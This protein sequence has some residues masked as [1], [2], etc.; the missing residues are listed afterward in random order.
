[1][2][3][4]PHGAVIFQPV[5][6]GAVLLHS[7]TEIYYGLNPVGARIWELIA[8]GGS[9]FEDLVDAIHEAYPDAER[10]T[11]RVDIRELLTDLET[12]G[13][14]VSDGPDHEPGDPVEKAPQ[15][16]EPSKS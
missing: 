6:E 10:E 14:L 3:L 4:R 15:A 8:E 2:M 7:E 16:L 9:T 13:L 12:Q 11:I 5:S 1:M